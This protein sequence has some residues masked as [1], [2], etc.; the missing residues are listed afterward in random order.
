MQELNIPFRKSCKETFDEMKFRKPRL[1][2]EGTG[3]V[4]ARGRLGE[5][6][7]GGAPPTISWEE[8]PEGVCTDGAMWAPRM[9]KAGE[10][11]GVK[12]W[13]IPPGLE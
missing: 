1:G 11:L 7:A 12:V 5:S 10:F 2:K 8:F 3:R 4:F 13:T 9:P 6:V